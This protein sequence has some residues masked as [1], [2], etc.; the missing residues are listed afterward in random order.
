MDDKIAPILLILPA[1]NQLGIE[2]G[3]ARIA[4]LLRSLL[5]LFQ[6]RLEFGRRDILP[7]GFV[8]LKRFDG[9]SCRRFSSHGYCF[10][11]DGCTDADTIILSNSPLTLASKSASI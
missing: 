9:F 1:P 4:D 11:V 7:L 2:V 6:Y 10:P 5:L 8:V 3:D